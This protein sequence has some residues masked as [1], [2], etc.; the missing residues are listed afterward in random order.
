MIIQNYYAL[1][2]NILYIHHLNS[3]YEIQLRSNSKLSSTQF[4]KRRPIII[5]DISKKKMILQSM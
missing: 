5:I 2:H 3:Y 1:F 4:L